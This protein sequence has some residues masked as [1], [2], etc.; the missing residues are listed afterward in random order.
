MVRP[1]KAFGELRKQI[2]GDPWVSYGRTLS[3]WPQLDSRSLRMLGASAPAFFI[4]KAE[5]PDIPA[6]QRAENAAH[7]VSAA[8]VPGLLASAIALT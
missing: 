2:G 8:L 3:G 4:T 1:R 6:P 7:A 5:G